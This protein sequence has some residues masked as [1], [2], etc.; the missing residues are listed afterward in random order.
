MVVAVV[1]VVVAV[2]AAAVVLVVVVVVVM[3]LSLESL[4]PLQKML[5]HLAIAPL[6]W[7]PESPVP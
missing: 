3:L 1:V 6:A 2:V 4:M 7:F 5:Q